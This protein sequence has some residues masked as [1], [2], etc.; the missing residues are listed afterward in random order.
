MTTKSSVEKHYRPLYRWSTTCSGGTTEGTPIMTTVDTSDTVTYGPN[1][2]NYKRGIARGEDVTTSAT[3]VRRKFLEYSEGDF[4]IYPKCPPGWTGGNTRYLGWLEHVS[5]PTTSSDI[6]L[7]VADNVAK[8]KF[9]K[10][11]IE[12][13][14]SFMGGVFLGELRETLHMIR[15][16]AK[17]IR[18]NVSD[19]FSELKKVRKV[20]NIRRRKRLL[21]DSWL[22]Y[23][24]GWLPLFNDI[25][26]ASDALNRLSDIQLHRVIGT[27]RDSD[28]IEGTRF[29]RT[30]G[31]GILHYYHRQATE[32]HSTVIYRGAVRST[33]LN[34]LRKELTNWGFDP[35]DFAPTAW[36]LVP[37]SFLVDYFSNI[38][39]V[40]EGWSWQ[41]L[42]L[43]WCNKTTLQERIQLMAEMYPD[44]P[45]LSGFSSISGWS[46]T[47]QRTSLSHRTW[48]RSRYTGSFIPDVTFQIPGIDSTKW[49]NIGALIRSGSKGLR[50]FF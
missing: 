49:I 9:L 38:G 20:R 28:R 46:F 25:K 34:P 11:A 3:G 40:I 50:P 19:Y 10:Q 22:E 44:V 8:G 47:P 13:H 43:S 5:M 23:S 48:N 21:Q 32:T 15:N 27:G 37:Y 14:R 42:G 35:R 1:P 18:R 45:Y 12:V 36:E 24:F 16:P 2:S 6:S 31:R 39:D 26:N 33:A 17:A 4:I 29:L 7:S 30:T 41:N